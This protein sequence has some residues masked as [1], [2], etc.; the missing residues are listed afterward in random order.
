MELP[1]KILKQIAFHTKPKMEE[2][3]RTVLDQSNHEELLSQ[4]L[5]ANHKQIKKEL[6]FF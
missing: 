4:P 3:M 5:Q 1:S 6:L 2:H